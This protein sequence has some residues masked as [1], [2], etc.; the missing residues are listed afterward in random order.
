M[1]VNLLA[2]GDLTLSQPVSHQPSYFGTLIICMSAKT[3]NRRR[4]IIFKTKIKIKIKATPGRLKIL[5]TSRT[6]SIQ[7]KLPW[8]Q[9]QLIFLCGLMASTFSLVACLRTATICLCSAVTVLVNPPVSAHSKAVPFFLYTVLGLWGN[10]ASTASTSE[11][12][13]TERVQNPMHTTPAVFLSGTVITMLTVT[14][15]DEQCS[16]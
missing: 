5:R 4:H 13:G 7:P 16:G 14:G 1:R 10:S 11:L 8:S 12:L 9:Q 15:S 6:G 3:E 2:P